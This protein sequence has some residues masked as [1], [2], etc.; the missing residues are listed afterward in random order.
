M[1]GSRT[2]LQEDQSLCRLEQVREQVSVEHR[3]Q[4]YFGGSMWQI[5]HSVDRSGS[6]IV[7]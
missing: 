2:P 4:V 6:S 7:V 1:V 3:G 5:V